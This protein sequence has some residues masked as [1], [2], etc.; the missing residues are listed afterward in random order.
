MKYK[1]TECAKLIH[2]VHNESNYCTNIR[3]RK[4]TS[5]TSLLNCLIGTNTS[6]LKKIKKKEQKKKI[7]NS[8]VCSTGTVCNS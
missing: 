6:N 4:K 5:T 7:N 1:Y 3:R 2:S 8:G